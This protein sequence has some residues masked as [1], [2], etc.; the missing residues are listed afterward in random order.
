MFSRGNVKE[1][2][3]VP[4]FE[5]ASSYRKRRSAPAANAYSNLQPD[6]KEELGV[7]SSTVGSEP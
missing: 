1:K 6:E 7:R 2:A 4:T 3:R 5:P